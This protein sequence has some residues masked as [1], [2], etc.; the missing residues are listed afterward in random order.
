M[1]R[2]EVSV[3]ETAVADDS[4]GGGLAFLEVAAGLL[5]CHVD[6]VDDGGGGGGGNYLFWSFV[7]DDVGG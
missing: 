1:L 2:A 3:A 4:L 7:V 6:D 5:G